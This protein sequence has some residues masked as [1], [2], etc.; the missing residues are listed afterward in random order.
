M[1]G[2]G[3]GIGYFSS[4]TWKAR[5]SQVSTF[6]SQDQL[7]FDKTL[8]D[9]LWLNSFSQEQSLLRAECISDVFQND[10]FSSSA[11]IT[12]GFLSETHCEDLLEILKAK[13]TEMW[14]GSQLLGPSGVFISQSY[15]H[16]ASSNLSTTAQVPYS[17]PG[18]RKVSAPVSCDSS[19][20]PVSLSN[21]GG[22]SLSC[23]VPSLTDLKR[24]DSQVCSVFYLLLG[25][26]GDFQPHMLDQKP[27]VLSESI[28]VFIVK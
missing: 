19:Y 12:G 8:E 25:Q 17:S 28:F 11:G 6:L 22:S 3:S 18:S 26:R 1:T 24:V 7:V 16:E 21:S 13:L 20:L 27:E 14:S 23:D 9:Q 10:S 15:P 5:A 2:V 4:L